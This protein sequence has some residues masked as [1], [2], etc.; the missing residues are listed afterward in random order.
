[1][2]HSGIE[3]NRSQVLNDIEIGS[4]AFG[5]VPV[6]IPV[7]SATGVET[8]R[9]IEYIADAEA[10]APRFDHVLVVYRGADPH[11]VLKLYFDL[12]GSAYFATLLFDDSAQTGLPDVT[13]NSA[14]TSQHA[15]C[16]SPPALSNPEI[17]PYA[18]AQCT[19][20]QFTDSIIVNFPESPVFDPSLTHLEFG[21]I[22]VPGVIFDPGIGDRPT[23]P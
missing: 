4:T 19:T 21:P 10:P 14:L 23:T 17:A 3:T 11:T 1:M 5:A 20:A 9:G 18:I 6:V 22:K 15:G 16:P 7:K 12:A 8:W 13:G 2:N